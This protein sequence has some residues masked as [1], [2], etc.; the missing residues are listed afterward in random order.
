[1]Y[2][3]NSPKKDCS[4][5][6]Q[7]T[8]SGLDERNETKRNKKKKRKRSTNVFHVGQLLGEVIDNQEEDLGREGGKKGRTGGLERMI[9]GEVK[10]DGLEHVVVV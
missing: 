7:E 2:F 9:T 6:K 3:S 1:M 10:A 8:R 4:R 5:R